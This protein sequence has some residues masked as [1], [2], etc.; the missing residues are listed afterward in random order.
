MNK[1]KTVAIVLFMMLFAGSYAQKPSVEN[2]NNYVL[3]EMQASEGAKKI[4]DEL[5]S[6][7]KVRNLNFTVGYTTAAEKSLKML[8][9]TEPPKGELL[10]KV[11]KKIGAR[12][13]TNLSLTLD[14]LK[15]L[16]A[17][18]ASLRSYDA[19]QDHIVPD[20]RDQQCG[21]CWAYSAVGNLEISYN[22]V[23]N[24]HVAPY[25]DLSEKQAVDCFKCGSCAGGNYYCVFDYLKSS[26]QKMM[27]EEQYPDNGANASCPSFVPRSS[28]ELMD[29]GVVGITPTVQEI[30]EAIC[31]YGPLSS[32]ILATRAFQH[33]TGGIFNE[34][35]SDNPNNINHAVMIIGWDDDKGAWL[36]RN[37]WG[38]SGWGISGYAWVKYGYNNIGTWVAWTASKKTVP[39]SINYQ[40]NKL[41]GGK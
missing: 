4:L 7:I 20:V 39:L 26:H 19:R 41:F 33:Y 13:D 28:V 9:A 6:E 27:T 31:K 38:D 8:A 40:S 16:Q 17:C 10:Q 14:T 36:V 5:R 11:T 1:S 25:N 15:L 21:D 37:S 23:N 30:K 32:C 12:I 24:I 35:L 29:W 22:R 3:R 34:R 18:S 2:T